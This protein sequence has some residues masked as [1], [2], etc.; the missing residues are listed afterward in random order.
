MVAGEARWTGHSLLLFLEFRALWDSSPEW[1]ESSYWSHRLGHWLLSS[2]RMNLSRDA[3]YV[4]VQRRIHCEP[5]EIIDPFWLEEWDDPAVWE[6]G[7]LS[8]ASF[9][10]FRAELN[11]D[12]DWRS[13][14]SWSPDS[15]FEVESK[16]LILGNSSDPARDAVNS[17]TGRFRVWEE[18]T[19]HRTRPHGPPLWFAIQDWY[20]PVEWHDNL[21]WAYRWRDER[22]PYLPDTPLYITHKASKGQNVKH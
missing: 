17:F 11:N 13:R 19:P 1:W 10:V 20:D 21:G 22:H 14:L 4:L 6:C 8:F 2:N 7:I 3:T 16:Y 5:D 18:D 12:E 9:A 15:T